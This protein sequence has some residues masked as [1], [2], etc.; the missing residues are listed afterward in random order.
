[1]KKKSISAQNSDRNLKLEKS[2]IHRLCIK[3]SNYFFCVF[4]IENRFLTHFLIHLNFNFKLK[5]GNWKLNQFVDHLNQLKKKPD[6]LC[7]GVVDTIKILMDIASKIR[8]DH[9]QTKLAISNLTM[10]RDKQLKDQLL[11][12]TQPWF[13]KTPKL[14]EDH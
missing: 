14:K 4:W 2:L 11:C 10:R 7:D 5:I 1:M 3:R 13:D 8:K 12:R 9:P 6:D